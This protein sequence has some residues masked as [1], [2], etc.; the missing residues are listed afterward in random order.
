MILELKWERSEAVNAQLSMVVQGQ[1]SLF[2][3]HS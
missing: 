2:Y 3:G 1:S